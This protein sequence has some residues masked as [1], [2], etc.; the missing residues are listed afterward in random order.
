MCHTGELVHVTADSIATTVLETV[1]CM[2][3]GQGGA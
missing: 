3:V 2:Y 1:K